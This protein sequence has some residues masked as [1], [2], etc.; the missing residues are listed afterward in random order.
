MS[1]LSAVFFIIAHHPFWLL[2]GLVVAGVAAGLLILRVFASSAGFALIVVGFV[3]GMLN[4]FTGQWLN[5]AFLNW[6]GIEGTAVVIDTRRTNSMLNNQHIV[7]YDVVL[8]TVDGEDVVTG[9]DSLSASI[10]P[11]RNAIL[12]PPQD[13]TFIV[14]YVPGFEKN[15][16]IMSDLSAYGKRRLI[17]EDQASVE[18]ARRQLAASSAN[19]AFIAEYRAAL[20]AFLARHEGEA[21]P[22]LVAQYRTALSELGF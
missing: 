18:R 5:A 7:E 2:A 13:E 3:A 15:I 10:W 16:V 8:R 14:R 19:P 17:V 9:F 12:I 6:A 1:R 22:A 20:T 11:I 4:I 21:D